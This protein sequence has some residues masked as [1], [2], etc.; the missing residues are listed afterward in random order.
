MGNQKQNIHI[1]II[2]I[3]Y[4]VIEQ[5]IN[6]LFLL[7]IYILFLIPHVTTRSTLVTLCLT[8][9]TVDFSAV[10]TKGKIGLRIYLKCSAFFSVPHPL[11]SSQVTASLLFIFSQAFYYFLALFA[12]WDILV[13]NIGHKIRKFL[14]FF[15]FSTYCML[16]Y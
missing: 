2:G 1:N 13:F 11:P 14:L 6:I 12:S 3:E 5:N 8:A 16:I 10:H 4:S 15:L 9:K 7:Y